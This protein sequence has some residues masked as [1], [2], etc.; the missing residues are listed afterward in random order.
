MRVTYYGYDDD[1]NCD[2]LSIVSGSRWKVGGQKGK[3]LRKD[4]EETE[5]W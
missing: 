2:T 5:E 1:N 3:E 4:K